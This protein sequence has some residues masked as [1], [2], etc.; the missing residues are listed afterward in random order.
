[1]KRETKRSSHPMVIAA[2]LVGEKEKL[3]ILDC[4]RYHPR[5]F[6][7]MQEALDEIPPKAL[8]QSLRQLTDDGL[9]SCCR[10]PEKEYEL[11]ELGVKLI[12]VLDY[13]ELFGLFYSSA[14][15]ARKKS[16]AIESSNPPP[17]R[18]G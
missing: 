7:A 12:P 4:L 15:C 18:L 8:T 2:A 1:M 16:L 9:I 11:S 14:F 5:S 6:C 17:R 3:R 13:L 10:F